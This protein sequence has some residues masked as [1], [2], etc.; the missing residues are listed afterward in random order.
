MRHDRVAP[1]PWATGVADGAQ[2]P[3]VKPRPPR[4]PRPPVYG[5]VVIAALRFCRAVQGTACGRLLAVALPDLVRR[6]RR[7]GELAID[8]ATAE[9]LLRISP[10]TIDRRLKNDRAKLDPEPVPYQPRNTAEGLDPDADVG[11]VDDTR[12]GFVEIDLI[13]HEGGNARGEFCFT[14][15]I[16]DIATG[17][18]ETRSGRN[19]AQKWVFA[20]IPDAT[21]GFPFPILGI[22]SDNGSEFINWELFHW[23][24]QQNR[25]CQ[26]VCVRGGDP[27]R[28]PRY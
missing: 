20:A 9:S 21:A 23:C 7:H 24:E 22:D 8:D 10:A 18:T 16:T 5:E 1:G 15:D 25:G 3:V 19:K 12:P 4:P 27:S 13:R 6:L 17:W 2:A 11:G 28:K 26:I 14:L